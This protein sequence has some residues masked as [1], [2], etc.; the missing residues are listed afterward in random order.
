MVTSGDGDGGGQVNVQSDPI[1]LPT[2][3]MISET[4]SQCV[5]GMQS[6]LECPDS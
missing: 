1:L 5:A 2:L 6:V 3:H 4:R